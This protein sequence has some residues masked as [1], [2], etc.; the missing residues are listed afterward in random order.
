[1]LILLCVNN[2]LCSDVNFASSTGS[3]DTPQEHKFNERNSPHWPNEK[4][5]TFKCG[6]DD[7]SNSR[8]V[9]TCLMVSGN[10]CS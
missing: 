7:K 1:M 9:F 3:A 2:K 4:G 5:T 6:L 10:A 8:S